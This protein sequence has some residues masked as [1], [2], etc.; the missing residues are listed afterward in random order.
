MQPPCEMSGVVFAQQAR[1]KKRQ[2]RRVGSESPEVLFTTLSLA[3]FLILGQHWFCQPNQTASRNQNQV[4]S[5]KN[6][7]FCTP[8]QETNAKWPFYY[9]QFFKF[10][11]NAMALLAKLRPPQ[12]CFVA[13]KM[14]VLALA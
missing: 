12:E 2:A 13:C 1:T 5:H 4:R 9:P 7:S 10:H 11:F 14:N 8:P 3:F 6:Q